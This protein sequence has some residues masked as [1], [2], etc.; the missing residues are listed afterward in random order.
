MVYVVVCPKCGRARLSYG[1]ELVR[2]VY[3]GGF[4][5]G[6]PVWAGDG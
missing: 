3:C 1:L 6:K 4:F 5:E 2:C